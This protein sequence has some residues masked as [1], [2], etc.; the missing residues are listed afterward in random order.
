M[1]KSF[2]TYEDVADE[3]GVHT[4]TVKRWAAEGR[5]RP[6]RISVRTVR[7]LAEDVETFVKDVRDKPGQPALRATA[8]TPELQEVHG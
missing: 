5:L 7:F 8:E 6:A 1:S 3:L 2:L 4:R